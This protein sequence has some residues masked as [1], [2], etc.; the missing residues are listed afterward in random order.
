MRVYLIIL[1]IFLSILC[2]L[3]P[4]VSYAKTIS[5]VLPDSTNGYQP[6][7]IIKK[8]NSFILAGNIK[9]LN[10]NWDISVMFLDRDYSSG[11]NLTLSGNRTDLVF[12]IIDF[13]RFFLLLISTSS[14]FGSLKK[15][16]GLLDI[17][18]VKLTSEGNIM[19]I[20]NLGGKGINY[21]KDIA[22]CENGN[23]L[24]VLG[25]FDTEGEDINE[26]YGGWDII[27]ALYSTEGELIWS[28]TLG[29]KEDDLP[30]SI[31]C[32]NERV[33]IVYSTWVKERKWD[34]RFVTLNK[35]GD[36]LHDKTFG[37]N[38]SEIVKKI[39]KTND[40]NFIILGSVDTD[41]PIMGDPRGKTDVFLIK[42]D[43][44]GDII[45]QKRFGGEGNDFGQDV[46]IDK[47]G[48]YW[49][50]GLTESYNGDIT[51]HIGGWDLLVF[52]IDRG[53]QLISSKTYGTYN[54]EN[55]IQILLLDNDILFLGCTRKSEILFEPFL[56][57][58]GLNDF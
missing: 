2:I 49:I 39:I 32:N 9:N 47:N 8:M 14:K 38:G 13:S 48:F 24:A 30:G 43:N 18:I 21:A 40:G 4:S 56:I 33:Y 25:R 26:Y 53:G 52:K 23:K 31:T 50:L 19:W 12:K 28:R 5:I 20:K 45:W 37:S 6:I 58:C 11:K 17:G 16:K 29:S 3:F 46:V 35:N 57:K 42:I 44:N 54:D 41:N 1:I 27:A 22:L 34:I 15:E 10:G 36:I 51:E 7:G 55:P